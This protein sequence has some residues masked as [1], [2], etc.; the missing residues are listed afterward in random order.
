MDIRKIQSIMPS[1]GF[2]ESF[3]EHYVSTVPETAAEP[4]RKQA[5]ELLASWQRVE[6]TFKTLVRENSELQDKLAS[7]KQALGG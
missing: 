3:I 7:A 5:D 6:T 1:V 2:V 4:L